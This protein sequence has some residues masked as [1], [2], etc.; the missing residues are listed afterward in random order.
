MN[1]EKKAH[2]MKKFAFALLFGTQLFA[3]HFLTFQVPDCPGAVA[4]AIN[5]NGVVTGACGLGNGFIR[6]AQGQFTWFNVDRG[7]SPTA[8]NNAGT[9]TGFYA[10]NGPV[11][12]T[13]GFIRS[14]DGA[15]TTFGQEPMILPDGLLVLISTFANGINADGDVVG[16]QNGGL[17]QTAFLFPAGGVFGLFANRAVAM[18]INE[19]GEIAGSSFFRFLPEGSPQG[20]VFNGDGTILRVVEP[21]DAS[22]SFVVGINRAGT[23]AGVFSTSRNGLVPIL[24]AKQGYI[25]TATGETSVFPLPHPIIL[26]TGNPLFP[27][28]KL[29]IGGGINAQGAMV[30]ENVYRAPDGTLTNIELGNCGNVQ[31]YGVNDNGIVAGSC[32]F[33]GE[34]SRGFLWRK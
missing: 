17:F 23:V 28:T 30:I 26:P 8:I 18:A 10:I 31:T 1:L 22:A 21:L 13:R 16:S 14:A 12:L 19:I 32:A 7:A 3:A 24:E 33:P 15:I 29:Q 6:N 2:L 5:N 25:E 34:P 9:I 20:V 27:I 11:S 4:T